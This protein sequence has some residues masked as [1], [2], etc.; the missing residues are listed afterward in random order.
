MISQLTKDYTGFAQVFTSD[1]PDQVRHVPSLPK[2]KEFTIVVTNIVAH[3]YKEKKSRNSY[4]L[5]YL[6]FLASSQT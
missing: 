1:D 6:Q 3:C 5:I 4:S 2:Y